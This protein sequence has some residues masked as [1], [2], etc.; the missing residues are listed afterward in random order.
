MKKYYL[1]YGSNLNINDMNNRIKNVKVVGTTILENY[2]LVYK[3]SSDNY[4]YLTI[5]YQEGKIVPLGIYEISFFDELKLDRYE[6]YPSLYHKE[7]L[8]I[9][10]D[11]KK[12][13]GLIYVMND[14]FS[15]HIPLSSY[16]DTCKKGYQDF[17]FC[18][19]VLDEALEYTKLNKS[20]ILMK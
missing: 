14:G 8:D 13:K 11:G 1:A 6:G 17:N 4:S 20:K 7:Y 2:R 3:G 18:P 19:E 5:E 12:S 15:Y 10:I 16:I 9:Q